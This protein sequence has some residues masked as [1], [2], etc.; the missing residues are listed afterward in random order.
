MLPM[1]LVAWEPRFGFD[2]RFLADGFRRAFCSSYLGERA[3]TMSRA[4]LHAF[5]IRDIT[6]SVQA[7]H[8]CNYKRR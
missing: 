4:V 6:M 2:T 5:N 8:I 1:L 7:Q 3:I